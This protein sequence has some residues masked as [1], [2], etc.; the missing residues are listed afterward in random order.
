MGIIDAV[1]VVHTRPLGASYDVRSAIAEQA[2]LWKAYGF[3]YARI[4]GVN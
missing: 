2:A 4:P 1:G 3:N